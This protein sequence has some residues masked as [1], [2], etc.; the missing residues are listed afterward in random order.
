MFF[1]VF[2]IYFFAGGIINNIFGQHV[3]KKNHYAN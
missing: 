1:F 3:M 2:F